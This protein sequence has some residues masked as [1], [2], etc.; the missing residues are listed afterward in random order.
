MCWVVGEVRGD[1]RKGEES[2][3][4]EEMW[5]SVLGLHTRTH[6]TTSPPHSSPH[7]PPPHANTLP[8]LPHTLSHT[9]PLPTHLSLLIPTPQHTSLH[10]PPH[11]SSHSSPHL[12]LHPNTLPT[13]PMHSP[14][15]SPQLG[16]CCEVLCDDVAL[17]NLTGLW[18][19]PI[20]FFTTT[21]NLK[22]CVGVGNVN[23]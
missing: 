5:G 20:K 3:V 4:R 23:F 12:H 22:S 8:H 17:I 6:F 16:L 15:S 18:K 19:S 10:L 2:E 13:H 1:I 7:I 11:T 9:S 21:G 14:T